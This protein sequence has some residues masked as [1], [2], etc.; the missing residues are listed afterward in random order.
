MESLLLWRELGDKWDATDCLEDL[1]ATYL[2]QDRYQSS[3]TIF[4]AA[5]AL[6]VEIGALRAPFEAQTYE[7]RLAELRDKMGELEFNRAWNA[8]AQMKMIEAVEFA[9]GTR[10]SGAATV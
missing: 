2:E 5:E 9:L 3:A 7:G 4:G 8:G 10:E 1:A 6:R